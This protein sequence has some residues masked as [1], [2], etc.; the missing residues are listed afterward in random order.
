MLRA[1]RYFIRLELVPFTVPTR[2]PF[3]VSPF[4]KIFHSWEFIRTQAIFVH[5]F[6]LVELA[7]FDAAF[8]VYLRRKWVRLA[9]RALMVVE[10]LRVWT[11]P[12]TAHFPLSFKTH[13]KVHSFSLRPK[14]EITSMFYIKSFHKNCRIVCSEDFEAYY[15]AKLSLNIWNYFDPSKDNVGS[16]IVLDNCDVMEFYIWVLLYWVFITEV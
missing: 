3:Q 6:M 8:T 15:R 5:N 10:F 4:A 9:L 1:F 2:R 13:A 11:N 7:A 16:R 12:L 14:L